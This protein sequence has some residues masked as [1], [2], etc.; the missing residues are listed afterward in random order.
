MSSILGEEEAKKKEEAGEAEEDAKADMPKEKKISPK[1]FVL[2]RYTQ[3]SKVLEGHD[4]E[5]VLQT[6]L[7]SFTQAYDAHSAYMSPRAI[8]DFDISMKLSLKGIGA[9]LSYD[10]GAAKIVRLIPGGPAERDG[11]FEVG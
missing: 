11:T 3:F 4:A 7:N 10:E 8:E 2:K 5:W 1:E 9:L 6:Y